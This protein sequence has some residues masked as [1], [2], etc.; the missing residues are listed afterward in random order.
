MLTL[1]R[2]VIAR[3]LMSRT[4]QQIVH[5][6]IRSSFRHYLDGDTAPTLSIFNIVVTT[7]LGRDARWLRRQGAVD[8]YQMLRQNSVS[9]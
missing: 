5:V 8:P 3:R 6:K 9:G 4:V 2:R 7:P 1:G